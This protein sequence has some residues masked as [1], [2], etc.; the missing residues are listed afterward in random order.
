[1]SRHKIRFRVAAV[2]LYIGASDEEIM[3]FLRLEWVAPSLDPDGA[4]VFDG[5]HAGHPHWH[6][7]RG[8]LVGQ[9]DYLRALE[10]LKAPE[11]ESGVEIFA[12]SAGEASQRPVHDC[13]WLPRVHLPAQAGWMHE[14][15]NANKVPGPHQCEPCSLAELDRW[16]VGALR[17][18][19]AELPKA[20]LGGVAGARLSA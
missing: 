6:I 9:D 4:Q 16:W 17:Y 12:P 10:A 2:R 19:I 18:L 14:E 5:M 11:V 8:A 3:Q 20:I 15:W 13:S 1:M 7:D